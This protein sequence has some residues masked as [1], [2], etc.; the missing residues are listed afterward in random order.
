MSVWSDNSI[1]V[2]WL[3]E[4]ELTHV[5]RWSHMRVKVVSEYSQ[6]FM[7]AVWFVLIFQ[8]I[9]CSLQST[10]QH[11]AVWFYLQIVQVTHQP[12]LWLYLEGKSILLGLSTMNFHS[13]QAEIILD[14]IIAC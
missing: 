7:L 9:S 5:I 10:V 1:T 8:N 14:E 2:Q 4:V 6:K 12:Y 3:A 13:C 11:T